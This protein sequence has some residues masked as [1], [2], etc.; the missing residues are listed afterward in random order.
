M[1]VEICGL[2]DYGSLTNITI[3]PDHT[4]L[5]AI[6]NDL[7]RRRREG[8][9][10]KEGTLLPTLHNVF[11]N[12]VQYTFQC[13][14]AEWR[15]N[16]YHS[17]CIMASKALVNRA[18]TVPSGALIQ[19][20]FSL[21]NLWKLSFENLSLFQRACH[22]QIEERCIWLET[23]EDDFFQPYWGEW[24]DAPEPPSASPP[25]C[26]GTPWVYFHS[27]PSPSPCSPPRN[28]AKWSTLKDILDIPLQERCHGDGRSYHPRGTWSEEE[29][30]DE[31]EKSI[32]EYMASYSRPVEF[33]ESSL[34]TEWYS[35]P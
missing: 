18:R 29:D 25:W 30:E 6:E 1:Q 9:G 20:N 16:V 3:N 32:T 11:E 26:N 10:D 8:D 13:A 17:I 27:S 22:V 28:T 4:A 5:A 19:E 14:V 34:L 31:V 24:E 21:E 15:L 35:S 7:S 23:M 33:E 12:I 2:D